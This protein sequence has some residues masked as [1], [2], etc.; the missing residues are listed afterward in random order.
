MLKVGEGGGVLEFSEMGGE[1]GY[2]K[3]GGGGVFE[4]GGGLNPSTNYANVSCKCFTLLWYAKKE[5]YLHKI[6]IA[7]MFTFTKKVFSH[8]YLIWE[9]N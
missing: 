4:M 5:K 2:P 3:W 9:P 7:Y 8:A 1:G 6:S